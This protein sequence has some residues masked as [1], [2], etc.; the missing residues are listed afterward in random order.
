[1]DQKI[2]S[3]RTRVDELLIGCGVTMGVLDSFLDVCDCVFPFGI[4]LCLG[5]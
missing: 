3:F 2:V 4:N 5:G 1:M